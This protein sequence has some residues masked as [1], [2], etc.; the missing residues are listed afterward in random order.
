[1]S[2]G[3]VAT[4]G[5]VPADNGSDGDLMLFLDLLPPDETRLGL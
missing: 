4:L 1:M 3:V 5:G 2:W